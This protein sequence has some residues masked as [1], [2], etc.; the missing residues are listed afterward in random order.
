VTG[1]PGEGKADALFVVSAETGEKKQLTHPQPQPLETGS[2]WCGPASALPFVGEYGIMPVVSRRQ[3]ER[4]SRLAYVRSAT[5]YNIWRID[6]P[7]PGVPFSSPPVVSISSTRM[8]INPQFS[9]TGHRVAFESDRAGE[10]EAWLSDLDGSDAVRL[11]T[12]GAQQS[13]NPRNPRWSRDGQFI[14]FDSNVEGQQE[15]YVM[16]H[17]GRQTTSYHFPYGQ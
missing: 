5:D 12:L 3:P 4:P 2:P 17:A 1:S 7:A 8:D 6:T 13:R 16:P 11:D 9:P 14:A 15:I 10:L